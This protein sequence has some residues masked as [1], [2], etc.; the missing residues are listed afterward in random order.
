MRTIDDCTAVILAGGESRRMGEDKAAILLAGE[1][2]LN[3]AIQSVQPL[4]EHLLISVREPREHLFFPQLCDRGEGGGPMMGISTALERVNTPWVFV[5]AC[6]MPFISAEMICAMSERLAEQQVVVA[7][8]DGVVQPLAAFYAKSSLPLMSKQI[9]SGDRSLQR[10]I[11][12]TDATFIDWEDLR[13]FDSE[14]LSF[15]DLDSKQDV[16]KAEGILRSMK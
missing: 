16:A 4:F 15:M 14:R 12:Q 1:P 13:P 9:A 2:L 3:R 7:V 11:K 10:L 6:D 8:V 5:L